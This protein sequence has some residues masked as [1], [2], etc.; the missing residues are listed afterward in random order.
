VGDQIVAVAGIWRDPRT[1]GSIFDEEV[2]RWLAFLDAKPEAR[3]HGVR[4]VKALAARLNHFDDELYIHHDD[5]FSDAAR[6]LRILKFKPTDEFTPSPYKP[7]EKL[8]VWKRWQI[9]S[10]S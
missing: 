4:I 5:R 9:Q 8:R 3:A 6:M 7:G 10:R 1:F 2:G